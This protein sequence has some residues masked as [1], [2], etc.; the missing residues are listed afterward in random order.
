LSELKLAGRTPRII[1]DTSTLVSAALRPQSV[2]YQALLKALR[3]GEFCASV[4]TLQELAQV[5]ER[6]KFDRYR[7]LESRRSFTAL[8]RRAA[9]VF[10]VQDEDIAAADPPCR[11]SRDNQFLALAIA[12][13][14]DVVVSSDEDVLVLHPWR[15]IPI[16]APAVF[17]GN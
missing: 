14:A 3:I 13:E 1:L 4:G 8:V 10:V 16:L 15:G 9:H 12:S 2:P 7:D 11:D 5:L 6:D 17:V